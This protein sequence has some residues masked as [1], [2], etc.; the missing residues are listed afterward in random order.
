MQPKGY[1]KL[2][3]ISKNIYN[4]CLENT[5][6]NMAITKIG[7]M[8][9]TGKVHNIIF[10]TVDESPHCIQ[11]HYIQDELREMMNLENINIKNYVVVNDELIEISP[12]LILLSKKLSELKEKVSI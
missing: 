1:E 12:E 10:A 9:R 4:L 2:E 8:I 6:V 11:M 3:K 5:H 7:G